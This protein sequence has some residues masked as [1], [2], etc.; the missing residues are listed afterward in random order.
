MSISDTLVIINWILSLVQR[1]HLLDNRATFEVNDKPIE[2]QVAL[3]LNDILNGYHFISTKSTL[4]YFKENYENIVLKEFNNKT[5]YFVS[6]DF[7]LKSLKNEQNMTPVKIINLQG[8]CQLH[9][10]LAMVS[11]YGSLIYTLACLLDRLFRLEV[12]LVYFLR[13]VVVPNSQN[14]HNT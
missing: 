6:S 2:Q 11:L 10:Y 12:C 7:V 1:N 9:Y 4:S 13:M 3:N 14:F 8:V 5:E